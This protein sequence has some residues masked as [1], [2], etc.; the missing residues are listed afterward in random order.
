MLPGDTTAGQ[1]TTQGIRRKNYSDVVIDCWGKEECEG[2][3]V[4]FDSQE[5]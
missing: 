5:D 2:V 3:C 1:N 4:G